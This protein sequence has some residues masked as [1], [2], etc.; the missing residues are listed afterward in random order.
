MAA[1][2]N[3]I[4]EKLLHREV[5]TAEKANRTRVPDGGGLYLL[6]AVKG[7][8]KAWRFDYRYGGNRKTLSL[9]VYPKVGLTEA[10]Q[11]RNDARAL[12]EAGKDPS[13]ER[14]AK[15]KEVQTEILIEKCVAKGEALPGS[16]R[17]VFEQWHRTKSPGWSP[18]Y[19]KKVAARIKNDV[20]PYLGDRPIGE[21]DEAALLECL[22]RVQARPA[23]ESAHSTLQNCGQIFRFGKASGVCKWN[24]ASG[25]HE[26]LQPVIVKHM[27]AIIDPDDFAALLKAIGT[28]RGSVQTKTALLVQAA[29]FQRPANVRAMAWADLD[30]DAEQPMWSI[31]S[32][33][34]KRT[35]QQKASGTPHLV[36][37]APDVV[38]W[39]KE[40]RNLANIT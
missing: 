15:R 37:L 7:G 9:G 12:L 33:Q 18:S 19:A 38:G 11:D 32:D 34:M 35:V 21:I 8:G 13:L 10:R 16:F 36:P 3:C 4:S 30:L 27:A 23:I 2:E 20:L 26:A 22:R 24:P 14:K 25:M 1:L 29:T 28:Y 6:L 40:L 5:T 17:E 39:L 31:P